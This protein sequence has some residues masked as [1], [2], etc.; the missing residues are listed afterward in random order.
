MRSRQNEGDYC[1]CPGPTLARSTK[2]LRSESKSL[3]KDFFAKVATSSHHILQ[4][5]P[6]H[7]MFPR[8]A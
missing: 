5:P 1:F 7:P 2:G 4:V 3:P 6:K 8:V